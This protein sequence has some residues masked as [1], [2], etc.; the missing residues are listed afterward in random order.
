MEFETRAFLLNSTERFAREAKGVNI[1]LRPHPSENHVFYEA[2]AERLRAAARNCRVALP[3]QAYFWDVLGSSS[4]LV[5]RS[6]VTGYE[7]WHRTLPTIEVRLNPKEWYASVDHDAGCDV[8]RDEGSFLERMNHYLAGGEVPANQRDVRPGLLRRHF[9]PLD[10]QATERTAAAVDAL[11]RA[12][13]PARYPRSAS[14]TWGC[15][16]YTTRTVGD[17]FLSDLKVYGLRRH[18][19]FGHRDRFVHFKDIDAWRARF[20]L[21]RASAPAVT[22]A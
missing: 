2:F 5:Q 9:G 21:L 10:G 11:A 17:F 3:I 19:R 6:C 13:A 18:D 4:V 20:R 8:V 14:H 15:L 1:V 12:S 16:K 7:A 22:T